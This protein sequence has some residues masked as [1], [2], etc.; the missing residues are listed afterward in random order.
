MGI[1]YKVKNA[2]SSGGGSKS[3]NSGKSY[4]GKNYN[5]SSGSKYQGQGKSYKPGQQYKGGKAYDAKAGKK[6]AQAKDKDGAKKAQKDQ[7]SAQGKDA[8]DKDAKK[9]Q[10]KEA[11]IAETEQ[12]RLE[13]TP[14]YKEGDFAE[15]MANLTEDMEKKPG[16]YT[17]KGKGDNVVYFPRGASRAYDPVKKKATYWLNKDRYQDTSTDAAVVE[18]YSRVEDMVRDYRSR[19]PNA[20][21]FSE[22]IRNLLTTNVYNLA[23]NAYDNTL[24]YF[25]AKRQNRETEAH[26][27][28]N[29]KSDKK[30]VYLM[31]GV[32]QNIGSQ[33]RLG[34]ALQKE[35]YMVYHLAADH[36]KK[37]EEVAEKAFKDIKDF[38]K[39][40]GIKTPAQRNDHFSGHSSG[41]DAGIFM[42]GDEKILKT[43]IKHVQARAPVPF[44]LKIDNISQR[45]VGMVASLEHD[46][47]GNS[48]TARKNAIA[49]AKREPNVPVYIVAGEYDNLALPKGTAY[50]HAERHFVIKDK[51]SSH[52]GTSGANSEMNSIMAHL[53]RYFEDNQ[54]RGIRIARDVKRAGYKVN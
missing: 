50:P 26:F 48:P 21:P 7:K 45:L 3:Y 37:R 18:E 27:K 20:K 9:H 5:S 44:G 4:A 33:W 15:R 53:H 29:P 14:A 34:E 23:R 49:M 22:V 10:Y 41:A 6:A 16:Q 32:A 35:G 43:G 19:M 1:E 42:A 2:P 47:V 40:T 38:H 24:G 46:D 30:I 36:N 31:H 52:F 39:K 28:K 25:T 17:I 54:K 11:E 13:K 51:N 12:E 8:H